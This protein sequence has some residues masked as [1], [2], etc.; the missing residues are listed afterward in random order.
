MCLAIPIFWVFDPIRSWAFL[1]V[2]MATVFP[3]GIISSAQ[4]NESA[5]IVFTKADFAASAKRNF[6]QTYGRFRRE[7]HNSETTWQ[8]ARA[9]FDLAEFSTNSTERAEIA[10][11]GIAACRQLI[12]R[13]PN[14]AVA[15]YYLGM[16]LGQLA[17]TKSLGALKL[18]DQME[19]EFSIARRLDESFDYAGPDRNLGLLY[20][21]APW[22][23]S[24]GS[25]PKARQHLVRAVELAPHY[26]ENRLNLLEAYLKWSDRNGARRELKALEAIWPRARTN[27][28]GQAWAPS[29]ADW[30]KRLAHDRKK[31]EES[32]KPIEAPRHKDSEGD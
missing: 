7:P 20:R 15:H 14:S 22:F 10:E 18:V 3:A 1:L 23:G 21:E 30:E 2:V 6:L 13:E 27:L 25:R 26:P 29:W 16:N 9:C 32:S 31:T 19:R 5:P 12:T 8:F 28:V 11:Q 4:T 24:I 17:Q